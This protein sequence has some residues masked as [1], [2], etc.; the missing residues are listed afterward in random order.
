[1]TRI[2]FDIEA[3][4]FDPTQVWCMV[5][6]DVDTGHIE[7]TK[8]PTYLDFEKY[9]GSADEIIGHNIIA[10]DLW[11]I[12]KLWGWKVPRGTKVTDTLVL[13]RLDNPSRD[14]GHS[15]RNWGKEFGYPKG[16]HN[17]FTQLTD[18]MVEYCVRD[19]RINTQVY[20]GLTSALANFGD[21]SIE[22]EHKVQ[23]IIAQ[24]SRTGW[25]LDQEKAN[26]LLG[27]LRQRL[28]ELE[29]EV[30]EVFQPLPVFIKEVKPKY[31][32]DGSLSIVGLKFLGEEYTKVS[33]PFSRVDYTPFN[34]GSRQQ[35][36]R[37]LQHFGWKPQTFT[38]TG[39]PEV[40]E[41]ILG[42]IKGIPEAALISEYLTVQKRIAQ[43]ESWV[44]AVA[45]D[46]R[47]HGYVNAIGA[48]TGRMT[49][50]SPN[51]AQV[52]ASYSPYGEDCRG[53]WTVPEGYLLVGCDASGL[54]LRMLAHYMGDDDYT[55]ELLHGDIHTTNQRAAGLE[56]RDQAK[57]FAYSLL[58]GAG[59]AKIGQ[60]VGGSA[61]RGKE[62]KERFLRNTPALEQLR[63]RVERASKRGFLRGLDGR[64]L[65]IRSEHA[66]LNTLL[67]S[68]GAIVMKQAMVIFDEYGTKN[69]YDFK[70]LAQI[71][72]EAQLEVAE[73]HAVAV[74]RL[75]RDSIIAAGLHFN[76][77]CPLA[78]EYKIGKDWSST[79]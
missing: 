28:W 48:V 68:A 65:W 15:L 21:E 78:A 64:R 27:E 8:Y 41:S 10:Y 70:Y 1:M 45:E 63:K 54:E 13:S 14:G 6:E 69:G 55:Q 50:S 46:G 44:E 32:A 2:V 61:R 29:Q 19:V 73:K 42:S 51:L 24:Q 23:A 72:D 52:P 75:Y 76:L 35:I 18:E 22:L 9:L 56:T 40:N 37:Y 25:L 16:D 66:A 77:R 5:T 49:H 11:A 17:D 79:H 58:Y 36:G 43:V 74:G 33:G 3:D 20:R 39:N 67:Q 53:C 57:T 31:K 71:H 34:L 26:S 4:G 62:L 38:P 59:D 7:V 30:R 12:D 60:V 47:V